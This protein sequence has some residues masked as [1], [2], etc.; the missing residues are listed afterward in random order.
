MLCI[1]AVPGSSDMQARARSADLQGLL[2]T[3]TRPKMK[4][5]RNVRKQE[6]HNDSYWHPYLGQVQ[7][8]NVHSL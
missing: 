6:V 7:D 5:Y 2:S 4:M 8:S 3:V 1:E